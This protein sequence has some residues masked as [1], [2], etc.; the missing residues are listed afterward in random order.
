MP[1]TPGSEERELTIELH[2]FPSGPSGEHTRSKI[3]EYL[4]KVG[5]KLTR[6]APV[7]KIEV[8]ANEA[9]NPSGQ[10]KAFTIILHVHLWSGQRFEAREDAFANRSKHI[11]L[12]TCVRN[13][14]KEIQEQIRRRHTDTR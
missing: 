3:N 2:R 4:E 5:V 13:A 8:F 1:T 6:R 12:E 7:R 9:R 14:W 10:A 11:G